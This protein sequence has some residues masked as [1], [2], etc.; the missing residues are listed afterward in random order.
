MTPKEKMRATAQA[1]VE[2]MEH[3]ATGCTGTFEELLLAFMNA[4]I[5]EL[6]R[7]IAFDKAR[8]AVKS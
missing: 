3:R 8:A 4:Q 6:D 7:Q 2:H 1:I 5:E